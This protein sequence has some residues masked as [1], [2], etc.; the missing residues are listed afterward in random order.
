MVIAPARDVR[1]VLL[2]MDHA[3]D[4]PV[5]QQVR[6][7]TDRRGEVGVGLVIQAEVALVLGA[8]HRLAQRA[9]HH[10]LDQVEVRTIL[11]A[12]QQGLVILR[13]R[14]VLAF[15]QGQAQL[16]EEGAQFFQALRRRAVV[17]AVQRRDFV[18]LQEFGG[19]HVGRQHAFLDQLVRIVA[20]G[21]ANF[22][23]LA[24]GTEDDPG[25]LG[26]S[27]HARDGP[28]AAPCTAIQLLEVRHDIGVL[29]AQLARFGG[30]RRFEH[31][32]TL[33]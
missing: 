9:Q 33:L 12:R 16:A 3:A 7:T 21:R 19:G 15:V 17:H 32:L 18:L 10:G 6:V 23:D 1:G 25:F 20:H 27:R 22:R 4:R 26:R 31:A 8:V 29:A 13:R 5:R 28:P 11:D 2:G 24:L 30:F 14:A